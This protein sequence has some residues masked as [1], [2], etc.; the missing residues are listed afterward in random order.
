MNHATV[1]ELVSAGRLEAVER[2]AEA[3]A[4]LYDG[5]RKAVAAHMPPPERR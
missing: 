2:D 3:A 5:A 1:P 4:L